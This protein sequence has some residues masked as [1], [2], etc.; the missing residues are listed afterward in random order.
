MV[1][2][3]SGKVSDTEKSSWL[4]SAWQPGVLTLRRSVSYDLAQRLEGG[5]AVRRKQLA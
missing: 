4:T 3:P 1:A 2:A 5:S